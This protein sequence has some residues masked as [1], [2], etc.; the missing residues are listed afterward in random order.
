MATQKRSR[1]PVLGL[2]AA[3]IALFA[4]Q[5]FA[6]AGGAG[7]RTSLRGNGPL[8]TLASPGEE[9][10]LWHRLWLDVP[11]PASP[12]R[13]DLTRV[14]PWLAPPPLALTSPS[15]CAGVADARQGSV[16]RLN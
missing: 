8:T 5:T 9:E 14:F 6:P 7:H 10:R 15:R 2:P 12:V 4:L 3:T 11:Q 16:I 13:D 1:T